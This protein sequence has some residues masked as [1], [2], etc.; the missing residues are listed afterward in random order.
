MYLLDGLHEISKCNFDHFQ[1]CGMVDKS[2]SASR[3]SIVAEDFDANFSSE[4]FRVLR[5]LSSFNNATSRRYFFT[6][7]H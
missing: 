7:D 1:K 6:C 3:W 4:L 2:S 5:C